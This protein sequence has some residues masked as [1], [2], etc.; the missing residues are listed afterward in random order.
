MRKN[1]LQLKPKPYKLKIDR[2]SRFNIR[3]I[4]N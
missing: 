4:G 2:E 1:A 3:T